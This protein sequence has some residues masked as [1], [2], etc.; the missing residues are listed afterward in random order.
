MGILN[1]LADRIDGFVADNQPPTA[2][3]K[4]ARV[5]TNVAGL[6][7]SIVMHDHAVYTRDRRG[8]LRVKRF[9]TKG[10]HGKKQRQLYRRLRKQG[11]ATREHALARALAS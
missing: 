4:F 7:K 1:R 11:H 10:H 9:W 2:R 5:W 6:T 8:A 3:S